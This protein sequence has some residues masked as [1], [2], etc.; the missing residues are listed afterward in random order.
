MERVLERVPVAAVDTDEGDVNLVLGAGWACTQ[1]EA[2]ASLVP[3]EASDERSEAAPNY[4][5]HRTGAFP[6]PVAQ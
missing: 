1:V 3:G 2:A 6:R 4:E 5:R